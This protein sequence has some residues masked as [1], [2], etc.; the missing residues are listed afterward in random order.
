MLK[1]FRKDLIPAILVE[2]EYQDLEPEDFNQMIK[3]A[4]D[5]KPKGAL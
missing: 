3:K 5:V 2:L 1:Y 4:V